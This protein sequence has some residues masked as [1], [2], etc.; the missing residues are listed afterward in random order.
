MRRM[1]PFGGQPVGRRTVLKTGLALGALEIAS[2]FPIRALGEEPVKVGM[3]EP[4]TGIYEKLA[5]AEV[6]GAR[7]ALE[8][9]NHSGGI[10]VTRARGAPTQQR[11][12]A[13]R[14]AIRP[15][16]WRRLLAAVADSIFAQFGSGPRRRSLRRSAERPARAA[17]AD[18]TW[19]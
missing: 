14:P 5:E 18:C 12:S 4:L 9:V 19:G 17:W 2:P 13:E 7:L 16:R 8:E 3:V 1:T 15:T 6:V 10:L 11:W